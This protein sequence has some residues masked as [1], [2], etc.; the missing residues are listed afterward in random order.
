M[1]PFSDLKRA[2]VSA[3]SKANSSRV[4]GG[5]EVVVG[6]VVR[7]NERQAREA[8]NN[9]PINGYRYFWEETFFILSYLLNNT[10]ASPSMM[11]TLS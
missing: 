2:S 3:S 8:M 6:A 11:V 5:T 10:T 4:G 9:K 7:S 1:Q